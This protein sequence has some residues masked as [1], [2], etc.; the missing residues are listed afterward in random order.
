M[1]ISGLVVGLEIHGTL[2]N[3]PQVHQ[4]DLLHPLQQ[5]VQVFLSHYAT[6][7]ESQW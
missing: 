7:Y 5:V 1:M 4:L 2:K 3:I 6:Q